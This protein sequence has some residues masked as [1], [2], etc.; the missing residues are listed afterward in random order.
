MVGFFRPSVG[1]GFQEAPGRLLLEQGAQPDGP[2][3]PMQKDSLCAPR[4]QTSLRPALGQCWPPSN[5]AHSCR[6]WLVSGECQREAAEASMPPQ[7]LFPT[8]EGADVDHEQA[9]PWS[10]VAA[11]E[12][13]GPSLLQWEPVDFTSNL[14][15]FHSWQT[16]WFKED[17]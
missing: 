6:L 3:I 9:L 8:E 7:T 4:H 17:F 11:K 5:K 10:P 13:G 14:Q 16:S 12:R 1:R 15:L 2:P